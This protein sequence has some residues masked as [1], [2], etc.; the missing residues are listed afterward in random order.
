MFVNCPRAILID[1]ALFKYVIIINLIV[2]STLNHS[3]ITD[4]LGDG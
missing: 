1:R 3:L 4:F 2:K